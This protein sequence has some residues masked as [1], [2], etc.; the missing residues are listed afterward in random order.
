MTL[1][2]AFN[3]GVYFLSANGV[4]EAEFKSLCLA[5]HL[6][7]IRNSEFAFHKNDE[8][9]TKRFADMLWRVKN[10]E[11]LQYVIGKWDFYESEFF[12]GKGVLI[13]RPETEE[14]TELVIQEAKKMKNPV[15]YDLCAGSGCIGL[16][17]AKAVPQAMVC[18]VE[19][20]EDA[21]YYLNK[22]AAGADNASV[23]QADVFFPPQLRENADII[24]SNP[25][26]IRSAEISS[27]QAEVQAEP[28][29][30]LDG[31]ADGLDFYRVIIDKWSVFL[32]ANGKIFFEI[33]NDQGKAV[34]ELLKD[35]GFGDVRI[36]KDIY[37]NDR[38]V[39]AVKAKKG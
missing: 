32:N 1:S 18:C 8:I 37:K 11:P 13:P 4:D 28:R 21:L 39:S 33:G 31:G 6:A 14:L 23:I 36:I 9:I 2:D 7:G 19:K 20:S 25:P 34:S 5:C 30:A 22:N 26:Y 38:I 10:G 12:V 16:S 15:V 35:Y 27:L 29:M 24:V 17:I 3:Y